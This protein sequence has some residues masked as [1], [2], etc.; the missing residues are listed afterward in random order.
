VSRFD[1]V[2]GLVRSLAIYYGQFWRYG[3]RREFYGQFLRPGD[4]AFDVGAHVGD[5]VRT[6]RQLG[7]RVVAIEP[8]PVMAKLLRRLY[9]KDEGVTLVVDALGA[10]PGRATLHVSTRTP[11]LTT[12]ASGWMRDVQADERFHSTEWDT[13]VDVEVTTLDALIEKYGTPRFC[14]IDVEGF[15]LEVLRGLSS[16]IDAISFEYIPVAKASAQACV[17]ELAR[18]GAYRFRSS[19]VETMRW[20]D[21]RWLTADEMVAKLESLALYDRS[22]DVY[23]QLEKAE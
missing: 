18:L 9:G 15:E 20:S 3:G 8:Q 21:E 23:A 14:K 13:A 1:E 7:A 4:L 10:Q 2:R 12:L 16:P 5:R 22:G 17:R 19:R 11:T 6:W